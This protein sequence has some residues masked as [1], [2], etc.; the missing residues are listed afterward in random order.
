MVVHCFGAYF[1]LAVAKVFNKK[2]MVGHQ[3]EGASYNSD[4]FAMIGTLFLWAFF[5]SFNSALAI[6]EDSRHRAI[7][8]T[9]LALCSST[10][11][12]FLISQLLDHDHKYRFSMAHVSNSVLAGGVAIG[13]VANIVLEPIYALLI[14]CLAAI[15]SVIGNNYIKVA[16]F[17]G[18]FFK[19]STI[20]MAKDTF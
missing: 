10:I 20:E 5:P 3:H 6:P 13:T 8:N 11:C 1:G 2:E 14:G 12:T 18:L 7:L 17:F 19:N 16:H 9:Y 15:V 4:I